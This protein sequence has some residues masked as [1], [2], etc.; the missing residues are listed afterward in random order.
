MWKRL[1]ARQAKQ[2]REQFAGEEAVIYPEQIFTA[3][4]R[5]YCTGH[6]ERY[7]E[8]CAPLS[9]DAELSGELPD[10]MTGRLVLPAGAFLD[11]LREADAGGMLLMERDE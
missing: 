5:A 1:T 11:D 9:G 7:L 6:T 10:V 8:V 4:G 2:Y 3:G